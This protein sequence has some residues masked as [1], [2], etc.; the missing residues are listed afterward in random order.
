VPIGAAAQ[1]LL[2]CRTARCCGPGSRQPPASGGEN[3]PGSKAE[4]VP[5]RRAVLGGKEVQH[6]PCLPCMVWERRQPWARLTP[7]LPAPGVT[8]RPLTAG[9]CQHMRKPETG[10]LSPD[11]SALWLQFPIHHTIDSISRA[12]QN[13]EPLSSLPPPP[14]F[15]ILFLGS[16]Q[17]SPALA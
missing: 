16:T 12:T 7:W 2:A 3:T 5:Q 15:F 17:K 8:K 14:F 13:M 1:Q 10:E 4:P 11:C 6:Q 9:H